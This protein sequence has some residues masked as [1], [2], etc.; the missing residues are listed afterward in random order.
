MPSAVGQI[1]V[2]PLHETFTA[3]GRG[4]DFSQPVPARVIEQIQ[5]AIDQ[6]RDTI[7]FAGSAV[8]PRTAPGVTLINVV[9]PHTTR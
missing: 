6:V 1:E 3:E 7:A 2:V 4:V 5:D 9:F 8:R